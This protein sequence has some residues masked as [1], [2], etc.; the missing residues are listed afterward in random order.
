MEKHPKQIK[1]EQ[2]RAAKAA[3]RKAMRDFVRSASEHSVRFYHTFDG[4]TV[5]YGPNGRDTIDIAVSL[6]HSKDVNKNDRLIGNYTA[7]SRLYDHQCITLRVPRGMSP[8]DL[9]AIM[10]GPDA[11]G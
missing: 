2:Q 5:A 4:H 9:L 8:V 3:E 7:A 1:A 6:L 11:H 10:F